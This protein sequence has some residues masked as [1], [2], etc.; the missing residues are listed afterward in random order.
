MVPKSKKVIPGGESS[1]MP[2]MPQ[3]LCLSSAISQQACG[4]VIG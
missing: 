3:L 2:G 1:T 4:S